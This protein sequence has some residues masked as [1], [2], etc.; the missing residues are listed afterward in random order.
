MLPAK[1]HTFLSKAKAQKEAKEQ[2]K[3]DALAKK[4]AASKDI[5]NRFFKRDNS[6]K[7]EEARLEAERQ[8]RIKSIEQQTAQIDIARAQEQKQ[9]EL[10]SQARI[11]QIF[12]ETEALR[13]ST[14][15]SEQEISNLQNLIRSRYSAAATAPTGPKTRQR[16]LNFTADFSDTSS[17]GVSVGNLGAAGLQAQAG[18]QQNNLTNTL[19][20]SAA[21]AKS[22]LGQYGGGLGQPRNFGFI[23]SEALE[24]ITQRFSSRPQQAKQNRMAMTRNL[25]N[26]FE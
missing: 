2:A 9:A 18:A 15:G 23:G 11:Q 1:F 13:K 21:L 22:K 4:N 14:T 7:L 17:L 19:L 20:A 12:K 3:K 16:P 5:F 10:A 6:K 8:A 26:V 24:Q 25:P